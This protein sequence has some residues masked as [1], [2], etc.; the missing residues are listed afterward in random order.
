MIKPIKRHEALHSLSHDHH[1]GLLL[2]WKIRKG[3]SMGVEIPRIKNYVNW[4]YLHHLAPHFELEEKHIF[5][6]LGDTHELIVKAV[7]DHA[8]IESLIS[9]APDSY[10]SLETFA[11]ALEAHI[12]FEERILFNEIQNKS[13]ETQLKTIEQIHHETPFCENNE[14]VFWL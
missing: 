7:A 2:S 10:E 4:F 13:T 6:V 8:Y 12:R 1:Q 11:A 14:D 5:P 9:D 3:I